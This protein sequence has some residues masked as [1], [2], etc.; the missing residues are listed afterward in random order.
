MSKKP[1]D[2]QTAR[3]RIAEVFSRLPN[4]DATPS[5]GV[6][7]EARPVAPSM[8]QLMAERV[9]SVIRAGGWRAWLIRHLAGL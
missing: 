4:T 7:P 3:K 2:A 1:D 5:P 8:E 6:L 9:L